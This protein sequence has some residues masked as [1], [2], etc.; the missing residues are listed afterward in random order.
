MSSIGLR[1]W[2]H[3]SLW[4]GNNLNFFTAHHNNY[5]DH[6]P[7]LLIPNGINND[8]VQS[9]PLTLPDRFQLRQL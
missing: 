3:Q 2:Y 6:T 8:M 4:P 9:G 1:S 5:R 7:H